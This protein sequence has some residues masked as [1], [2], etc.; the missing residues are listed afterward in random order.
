[1]LNLNDIQRNTI[2][3]TTTYIY[4]KPSNI[5]NAC[6]A[7]KCDHTQSLRLVSFELIAKEMLMIYFNWKHNSLVEFLELFTNICTEKALKIHRCYLQ[8]VVDQAI[9]KFLLC[10][11]VF[12]LSTK[13]QTNKQKNANLKLENYI[14]SGRV[15]E[16][17][18]LGHS[19]SDSSKGL[20]LRDKCGARIDGSFAT[21]AR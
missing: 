5:Q 1:M 18:S 12:V 4:I 8:A 7:A 10:F 15:S 11:Y 19:I 2:R 14:F 17:L 13:I 16:N 9:L 6:K 3:R 21:K 20:L